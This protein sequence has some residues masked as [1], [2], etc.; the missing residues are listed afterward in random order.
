MAKISP[1]TQR[2]II[3]GIIGVFFA[4][5]FAHTTS[6]IGFLFISAFFAVLCGLVGLLTKSLLKPVIDNDKKEVFQFSLARLLLATTVVAI[7]LGIMKSLLDFKEPVA[8]FISLLLAFV[9]GSLTLIYKKG[10]I[11]QIVVTI[12]W[13][14]I[15]MIFFGWI[16]V[17][18]NR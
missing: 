8:I 17:V 13:F 10:D 18:C 6:L 9:A 3:C 15:F 7:V 1:P 12:L 4:F 5:L 16:C 14:F 11:K 2:V